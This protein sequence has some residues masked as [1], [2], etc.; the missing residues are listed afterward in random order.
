MNFLIHH[1]SQY[2]KKGFT[3]IR[4][5]FSKQE[6]SNLMKELEIVKIKAK[7]K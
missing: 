6:I 1:K 2:N 7:K 3:I 5:I 4:N